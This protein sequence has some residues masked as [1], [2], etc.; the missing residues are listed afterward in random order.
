MHKHD[1]LRKKREF[2]SQ[3]RG[4]FAVYAT[5]LELIINEIISYYFCQDEIRRTEII[6]F[7]LADMN[8]DRKKEI[9]KAVLK[10]PKLAKIETKQKLIEKIQNVQT[11]RNK[12]SHSVPAPT[13]KPEPNGVYNM[14]VVRYHKGELQKDELLSNSEFA[15][16][17]ID[18]TKA[19]F[20]LQIVLNLIS[21]D[22]AKLPFADEW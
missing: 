22:K 17:I 14:R 9:L 19:I 7:I 11:F 12:L 18:A 13:D 2:D 16:R 4:N 20:H 10:E 1:E 6:E 21:G 8:F 15:L 5:K 3:M